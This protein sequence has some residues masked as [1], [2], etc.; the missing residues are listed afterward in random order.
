MA[1]LVTQKLFIDIDRNTSY[2]RYNDLSAS[3][4][5][6]FYAGDTAKIELHLI[7]LTSNGNFPMEDI[8]FPSA[9][10]TAAIG[11]PGTLVV[12]SGTSWTVMPQPAATFVNPVL[13]IPTEA[14]KGYF[15]LRATYTWTNPVT[16]A[17]EIYSNYTKPIE[18]D[19]LVEEMKD[20]LRSINMIKDTVVSTAGSANFAPANPYTEGEYSFTQIGDGLYALTAFG[21]ITYA[22]PNGKITVP[23]V[24]TIEASDMY[25][26][27]GYTGNLPLTGSAVATL[28]GTNDEVESTFEVQCDTGSGIQTYYQFPCKVRQQ[29]TSP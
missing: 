1:L 28:L 29:I 20:N 16:S 27:S 5:L 12:A 13:K 7:R 14:L 21:S 15:K 25:G 17:T 2:Q 8:T 6:I 23:A 4:D 10:I 19:F 24:Y 22:A 9:N 3:P 26:V 11:D 18:Y